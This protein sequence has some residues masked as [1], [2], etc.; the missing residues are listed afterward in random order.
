MVPVTRGIQ[1]FQ[2]RLHDAVFLQ[3]AFFRI[4][5]RRLGD[6]RVT[7]VCF[8][9]VECFDRWRIPPLVRKSDT[10]SGRVMSDRSSPRK[11]AAG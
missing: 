1:F 2:K 11:G 4:A 3:S 8:G 5:K 7:H 10:D 6:Q 9:C